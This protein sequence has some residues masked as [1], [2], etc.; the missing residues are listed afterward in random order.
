VGLVSPTIGDV[1]GL[2]FGN[3]EVQL[4]L[5]V[6]DESEQNQAANIQFLLDNAVIVFAS[7]SAPNR[8]DPS[9][10]KTFARMGGFFRSGSYVTEDQRDEVLKMDWTV[11]P[12]VTNAA[13]GQMVVTTVAP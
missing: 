2:L 8:M 9:F 6:V 3:P 11:L 10:G 4:S 5:M 7:N 12:I 1:T 13:A